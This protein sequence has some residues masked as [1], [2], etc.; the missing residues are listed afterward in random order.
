MRYIKLKEPQL[1]RSEFHRRADQFLKAVQGQLLPYHAQEFVAINMVTGEY[2]LGHTPREA[3]EAFE[4]SWPDVLM[5]R[6]RVDG[7][8]VAKFRGR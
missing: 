1:S 5:F 8:P 6:C 2:T 7:G 3:A 4:A